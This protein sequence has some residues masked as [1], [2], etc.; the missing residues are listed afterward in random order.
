MDKKLKGTY[1]NITTLTMKLKSFFE[2]Q[3]YKNQVTPIALK[4]FESIIESKKKQLD[5]ISNE[6]EMQ[7]FIKESNAQSDIQR[8]PFYTIPPQISA[9]EITLSMSKEFF[10]TWVAKAFDELFSEESLPKESL[11]EFHKDIFG[12]DNKIYLKNCK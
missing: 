4:E 6:P 10:D 3:D 7:Q 1:G 8:K 12:V 2:H 5:Q 11:N 9:R